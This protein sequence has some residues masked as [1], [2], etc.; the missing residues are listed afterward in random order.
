MIAPSATLVVFGGL[1]GVG[2][3]S[4]AQLLL[5]HCNA[6]YLRIDTIEQRCATAVHSPTTSGQPAI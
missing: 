6:M 4:I 5:T 1:P 3:S 2:K